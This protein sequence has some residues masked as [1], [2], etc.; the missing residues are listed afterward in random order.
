MG[1]PAIGEVAADDDLARAD[2]GGEMADGFR[3][4]DQRVEIE[5]LQVLGRLLLELDV[6]IAAGRTDQAGM[7]GAVGV[8]RQVAAAVRADDLEAREAVERAL[9]DQM[10][11]RNG[12]FQRIADGAWRVPAC[13]ADG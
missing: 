8:G 10:R 5:L 1:L 13:P 6:G 9:E 2:L 3:R 12:G 4:E 7:V 11:Q